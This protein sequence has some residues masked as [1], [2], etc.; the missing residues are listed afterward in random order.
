MSK[1]KAL[2]T[3]AP[4]FEATMERSR[5]LGALLLAIQTLANAIAHVI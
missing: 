2:P 1:I 3:P 5:E 4:D